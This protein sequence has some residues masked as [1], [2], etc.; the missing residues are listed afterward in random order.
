MRKELFATSER[1]QSENASIFGAGIFDRSPKG[2]RQMTNEKLTEIFREIQENLDN[3]ISSAAEAIINDTLHAFSLK[4][5]ER[6]LLYSQLS[7]VYETQGRYSEALDALRHFEDEVVLE[8]LE[9]EI[10]VSLIMQ[11]AIAYNNAGDYPKAVALL[12]STLEEAEAEDLR[13]LFG[14]IYAALARVYRKLNEFPIARD[15]AEKAL[16]YF[17]ETGD[18]RGMAESYHLIAQSLQ[19]GGNSEK[20][21][22]F[23][24]QAIKI[25]GSRSAPFLLGKI[26]S[27]MSGALWFL[28]RPQE[29]ISCLEKSI[30]FFEQ[31]EHKVQS[32]AA[33]NNLGIN[34]MLLG[35]WTKAEE[36]FKRALELAFETNHRHIAGILDSLGELK[37]LRGD[38]DQAQEL[39][40]QGVAL[41]DERKFEWY[42]IQALRN[43]ARCLLLQ[44]KTEEAIAKARETIERCERIGDRQ[45]GNLA[46][47]VLAEAYFK[48]GNLPE[49]EKQIEAIEM[50][51]PTADFFVLGNIQRIRGLMA[52]KNHSDEIALHH[53]NRSL[54]IFET[55][56]DLYHTALAQMEIGK[57]ILDSEPERAEKYLKSAVE[58][59][60]RLETRPAL[61]EAKNALENL[62]V[63]EPAKRREHSAGS[64][65]LMLRLAEA[66]ASRELL[67]RELV[68]ILQQESKAKRILI[69]ESKEQKIFYPFITQ[70][71]TSA[72]SMELVAKA[73]QAHSSGNLEH[74]AKTKNL[75]IF[76]LRAPSAP[77]A[78]LMI[79]PRSSANLLDGSLLQPLLR[80][81]ELGMDVCA[82]RE[83][84]KAQ[85]TEQEESPFTSQSLMQGFIHS[86]PAMTSLVEEVYKIRSSDV[87]VLV[88][89]E[90]GTGKELV[91]RA[92][93]T[94]SNR[95]DKVFVPFNC[96]AV[97]KEL[98]EGHLFGYRKGAFTGAV[99]D[100]VG[101]IR[102][103]NGG[104]LFLDE[105]GDLPLEV[106]PKLLRFLQEGEIQPLGEKAP[107]KV[108]VRVIAA[109]NMPLEEKV[110]DGTFR[111]DLYYRLNVIRLRVPP[112]RE[113]RSEIPP[114]VN[115]YLNQY[116]ARFNKRDLT[117]TP[118]TMDL[119]MV[120][121]WE[122][123]VRQLCN[124]VQRIVARAEDGETITPDHLSQ[125]LKRSAVPIPSFAA[126][127]GN[128][129][130]ITNFNTPSFNISANGGTLE[131]A[132]SELEKRMIREAMRRHNNNISRV[133][134]ELGLTRRGLYLKL[135]RYQLDKAS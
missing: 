93:H 46:N 83:K 41:A 76:L 90:S 42:T 22:E 59:F 12:K 25:I 97:P 128:I 57:T 120:C 113:R 116:S 58:I 32:T 118:Q 38:Y 62:K 103:A 117:M 82:L 79:Y 23:Y 50:T 68:A 127:A 15:N 36:V 77:P 121:E 71:F 134:R 88:T 37:M 130:Q 102:S 122:G 31:T 14:G 11:I 24:N 115:Y 125:D 73:Q 10:R 81:V 133:A 7:F 69:A 19:Q 78:M 16:K 26:Y 13:F 43:L 132:V 104:T 52:L 96:T 87:T 8:R 3:G 49:C 4:L 119:L 17:R 109:T 2:L 65:L 86:S 64:Q 56:E 9:P 67:F 74:F 80:V 84:D 34:L 20:S 30:S 135:G 45:V 48:S 100:S 29:G 5:K 72:E 35:A 51:D 44:G 108:D 85:Q 70:G 129:A 66:V 47:L 6:I 28:R 54:S 18:W 111:E 92:I 55:T 124:E 21:L 91:S 98:A 75:S 27:D 33:Y 123:N 114:I 40:E 131:E 126:A 106:Q 89:G 95:K 107:I 53:F 101:V 94:L 112:L 63:V 99:N 39:L 61:A 105:V 1:P 110:A 60:E